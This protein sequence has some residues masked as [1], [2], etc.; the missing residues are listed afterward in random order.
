MGQNT[1]SRGISPL[2]QIGRAR[3]LDCDSLQKCAKSALMHN[4]SGEVMTNSSPE[5]FD[6]NVP[7]P[8]REPTKGSMRAPNRWHVHLFRGMTHDI[9]RRAP[10]FL[11][12]WTDSWD[13][14]VVPAT[15][16]MFFAK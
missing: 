7:R 10:Y 6:D 2:D 12:D 9:R 16:Y 3:A 4:N 15:V 11:S 14:R 1:A 8:T 13:Y 5:Q